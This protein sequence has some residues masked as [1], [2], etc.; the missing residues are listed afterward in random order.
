MRVD[1]TA[2]KFNQA[3]LITLVLLAYLLNDPL[4]SPLLVGL[5]AIVLALG[6]V[7]PRLALFKQI[8]TR[9]VVPL[10]LVQPN[11]IPDDPRPHRFAQGVG[12]TF[13]GLST[14]SLLG[15]F[16]IVGWILAGI[17]VVL[18]AINLFFGFC[19]G[20]FMYYQLV[21]VGVFTGRDRSSSEVGDA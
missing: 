18:A 15:G 12:A 4:L 13:L 16:V 11:V 17:V 2:I 1:Q 7:D 9:I 6:T 21:R 3:S 19:A 8:Y 10:G 5:D 14:L 20:C